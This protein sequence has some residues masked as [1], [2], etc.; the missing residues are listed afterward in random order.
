MKDSTIAILIILII[1]LVV[2]AVFGVP[3]LK[4]I[5]DKMDGTNGELTQCL[6]A[7]PDDPC[8]GKKS[9]SIVPDPAGFC[10]KMRC[11]ASDN[12]KCQAVCDA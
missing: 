12:L 11:V 7:A 8:T 1:T 3:L 5:K 4:W 10:T 9:G 2:M 6:N